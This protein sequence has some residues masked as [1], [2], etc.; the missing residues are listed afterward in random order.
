MGHKSVPTA[1]ICGAPVEESQ[2]SAVRDRLRS[3]LQPMATVQLVAQRGGEVGG[4]REKQ[5]PWNV[6]QPGQGVIVCRPP[7]LKCATVS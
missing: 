1:S 7:F 3:H 5:G 2:Q 4:E 6:A